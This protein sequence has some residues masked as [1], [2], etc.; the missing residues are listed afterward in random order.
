MFA[1]FRKGLAFVLL[2]YILGVII[3]YG[4]N[5]FS[6]TTRQRNLRNLNA[7]TEKGDIYPHSPNLGLKISL[8]YGKGKLTMC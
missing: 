7:F 2:L 6:N 3:W 8:P 1:K 5:Q 4:S